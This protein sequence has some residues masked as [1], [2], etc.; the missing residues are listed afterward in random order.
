M[1]G[2]YSSVTSTWGGGTVPGKIKSLSTSF[3]K[4]SL[5]SDSMR[6]PFSPE[7][8]TVM[9]VPTRGDSSTDFYW[10]ESSDFPLKS[11][12]FHD[13]RDMSHSP[14]NCQSFQLSPWMT[15]ETEQSCVS[16]ESGNYDEF[17]WLL[18]SPACL[19]GFQQ[20]R[21][22]T[23]SDV[24]LWIPWC[25]K[26]IWCSLQEKE[27]VAFFLFFLFF[28]VRRHKGRTHWNRILGHMNFLQRDN[29]KDRPWYSFRWEVGFHALWRRSSLNINFSF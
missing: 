22:C 28:Q 8:L 2:G 26:V 12:G 10:E 15:S 5:S 14:S 21:L 25:W 24:R 7:C 4:L 17:L 13:A 3:W 11:G 27:L 19:K 18:T 23:I 16:A 9:S 29:T 6:V 1:K 20:R